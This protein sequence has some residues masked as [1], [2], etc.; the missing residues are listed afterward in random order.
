MKRIYIIVTSIT[1]FLIILLGIILMPYFR[2]KQYTSNLKKEVNMVANY[3]NRD[4]GSLEN[5]KNYI[6]KDVTDGN[7]KKLEK[8]IDKYLTDV[9]ENY[10]NYNKILNKNGDAKIIIEFNKDDLVRILE[11]LNNNR[12]SL[13][14]LRDIFSNMS[15]EKYLLVKDKKMIELYSK[16]VKDK[17]KV[18]EVIDSID[19]TIGV[20]NNKI[21]ILE[22]LQDNKEF[23]NLEGKIVFYKRAKFDEFTNLMN[24]HSIDINFEL[25]NDV[26]GPVINGRNVVITQGDYVDL[27]NIVSCVD[28]VD[29]EVLCD[30]NGSYNNDVPGTYTLN[31]R[32]KDVSKNESSRDINIIVKEKER[33]NLP[34]VIEVI[35]NQS[36]T[37]VYGQDENGEYTKI[38]NVFVCSPGAGENTPVGTFYSQKG[39]TW[40]ALYGGVYGQYSTII[41]GHYLFHSVPYFSMSKDSLWWEAY[42]QLGSKV[43]MGCIRLTVND[44]KWIYDNCPTGTMINIHDG[45]LPAGVQKPTAQ[46][47]SADNPNKGWD[48]TDPDS[49]N[50]WNN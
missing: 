14:N 7:F 42:N 22:Y 34:Y 5:I 38:V 25:V 21:D 13:Y 40:G 46:K 8:S 26:E 17:I 32:A 39:Y 50:P 47:I 18:D 11:N 4:K 19:T 43:S 37:I 1:I 45:D 6:N 33:Y 30:I 2:Q 35:R 23:Y 29:G 28:E 3:V 20:I 36:T 12:D 10:E 15:A 31:I 9:V 24:D 48:P 16:I 27:D 49:N 41:T 44:A